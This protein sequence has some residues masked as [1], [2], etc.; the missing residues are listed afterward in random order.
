MQIGGQLCL[1]SL[2]SRPSTRGRPNEGVIRKSEDACLD[3]RGGCLIRTVSACPE[4]L[5]DHLEGTLDILCV[6]P[7]T[8][9]EPYVGSAA[10]I[11]PEPALPALVKE[12]CSRNPIDLEDHEVGLNSPKVERDAFDLSKAFRQCF[13]VG[14]V[15][16]QTVHHAIEGVQ[17]GCG[18]HSDLAHPA[19][20]HL[21]PS[22]SLRN[23]RVGPDQNASSW[24]AQAFRKA[25]G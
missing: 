10:C 25:E 17:T 23:F 16:R 19:P 22:P 18:E 2:L 24:G 1:E 6:D 11:R 9:D 15:L 20:E 12:A 7:V 8:G 4:H 21:S 3:C 14:M 5:R 13:S